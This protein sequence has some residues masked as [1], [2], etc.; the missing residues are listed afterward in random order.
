VNS[1]IAGL[2]ADTN[3]T[4]GFSEID[5]RLDRLTSAV[6]SLVTSFLHPLVHQA[7]EN[8]RTIAHLIEQGERHKEWLDA[9]RQDINQ[10]RKETSRQIQALL[11]S[12]NADRQAANERFDAMQQEIRQNQ[13]L[14]LA[15][16][17]RAERNENRLSEQAERLSEQAE[18]NAALLTEVLSLSRR[19]TAVENAA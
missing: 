15:G 3:T 17:Q 16:Q 10:L 14:I 7:I 1:I 8:Q 11:D 2:M 4:Q 5:R 9:D 13:R 19:V 18:R 6:D 12:A